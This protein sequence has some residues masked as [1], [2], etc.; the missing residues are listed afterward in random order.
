MNKEFYTVIGIVV[1][2]ALNS[3]SKYLSYS[4]SK[5]AKLKYCLNILFDEIVGTRRY[6]ITA[7]RL[8]SDPEQI[9]RYRLNKLQSLQKPDIL[10]GQ[11]EIE[12][13]EYDSKVASLLHSANVCVDFIRTYQF[14]HTCKNKL[15]Y[16]GLMLNLEILLDLLAIKILETER[17]ITSP[18]N[19]I[20]KKRIGFLINKIKEE[21]SLLK[22]LEN[23]ICESLLRIEKFKVRNNMDDIDF[24]QIVQ[25]VLRK[26]KDEPDSEMI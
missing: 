10:S 6:L 21:E 3:L 2:W 26:E 24:I 16:S 12:I 25:S 9:E 11:F 1:G 7:F 17:S 23:D 19:Y 14:N 18:I 8:Y 4:K 20:E 22:Y 15:I 5:K 13:S